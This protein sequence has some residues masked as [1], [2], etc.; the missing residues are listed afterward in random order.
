[1]KQGIGVAGSGYARG[2]KRKATNA[3]GGLMLILVVAAVLILDQLRAQTGGAQQTS[4]VARPGTPVAESGR[5]ATDA[6]GSGARAIAAAFGAQRS[7][8]MVES[9][10]EVTKV[11][12]DDEHPPRHQRF[13]LRL[14]TGRTVLMSHNIDLAERVPVR[15]GDRVEFRGQYEWND[16]GGV[17]HWTHHDPAGRREGGWIVHADVRYE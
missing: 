16:Q 2:M 9:A 7:G 15:R 6:D 10:G 14:S 4:G 13:I 5:R 3:A 17:I 12:P 1:M 8:F 11:L